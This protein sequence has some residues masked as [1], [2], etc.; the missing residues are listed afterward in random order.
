MVGTWDNAI[1]FIER[2]LSLAEEKAQVSGADRYSVIFLS[3]ARF[4][5]TAS[6]VIGATWKD[7]A[8]AIQDVVGAEVIG[9]FGDRFLLQFAQYV[10]RF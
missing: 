9:G 6:N 4:S 3:P 2:Y 10:H 7:V 1:S 5:P 8:G